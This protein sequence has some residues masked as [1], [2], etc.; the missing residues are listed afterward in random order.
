M[1]PLQEMI[2]LYGQKSKHVVFTTYLTLRSSDLLFLFPR[3]CK[4]QKFVNFIVPSFQWEK[5]TKEDFIYSEKRSLDI[6]HLRR[7]FA[8]D[9]TKLIVKISLATG[10]QYIKGASYLTKHT[11]VTTRMVSPDNILIYVEKLTEF[12]LYPPEGQTTFLQKQVTLSRKI[13][14]PYSGQCNFS[15]QDIQRN[16]LELEWD[17]LAELSTW[18]YYLLW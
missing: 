14:P 10:P 9:K 18:Y 7:N 8:K 11:F 13:G 17:Y 1:S 4:S 5:D 16:S 12:T 15:M 2:I 3:G 6:T